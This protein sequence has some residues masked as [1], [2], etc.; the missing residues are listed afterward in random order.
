MIKQTIKLTT[1]AVVFCVINEKLMVLLVK[2]GSEPYKG[3]WALPGGF[4]EDEEDLIDGM[5]RELQEETGLQIKNAKQLRTYGTPGRDPRGR[6][7]SVVYFAL[8]DQE[9]SEITAGDDAAEAE[10]YNVHSLPDLAFDHA[11]ILQDALKALD[12]EAG[13]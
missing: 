3:M 9:D 5:K 7:V 1:D 4:V 12:G 13:K 2:R 10:W 6:T 11:E 8:I